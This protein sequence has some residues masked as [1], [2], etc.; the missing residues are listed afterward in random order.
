MVLLAAMY[1]FVGG[2]V[3]EELVACYYC[4]CFDFEETY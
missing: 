1:C 3:L 2:A 4:Y